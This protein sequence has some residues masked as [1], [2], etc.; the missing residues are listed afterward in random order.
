MQTE[1]NKQYRMIPRNIV[2]IGHNSK[3]EDIMGGFDAFRGEQGDI[4][5]ITVIDDAKSLERLNNYEKYPY[6]TKKV[7]A[8]I[9]DSEKI[10][11]TIKRRSIRS[12]ATQVF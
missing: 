7:A 5:N 9:Y 12:T 8:D 11:D 10:K 3:C 6:V 2:I 1:L 4:L